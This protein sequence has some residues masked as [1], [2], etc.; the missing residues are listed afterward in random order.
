MKKLL[1]LGLLGLSSIQIFSAAGGGGAAGDAVYSDEDQAIYDELNALAI[2][3]LH[4]RRDMLNLDLE[5]RTQE[6][7]RRNTIEQEAALSLADIRDVIAGE[8]EEDNRYANETPDMLAVLLPVIESQ[9]T[10]AYNKLE[11]ARRKV[12]NVQNRLD[13]L[14]S[15]LESKAVYRQLFIKNLKT[16]VV[17]TVEVPQHATVA[18]IIDLVKAQDPELRDSPTSH[19]QFGALGGGPI[20]IKHNVRFL[21]TYEWYNFRACSVFTTGRD[22]SNYEWKAEKGKK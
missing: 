7:N 1:F 21:D 19:I 8:A 22:V 16:Q 11:I 13:I 12:Q 18:Q 2:E 20:A 17:Y 9:H 6:F 4:E 5:K 3:E 10:D 15:I 14:N